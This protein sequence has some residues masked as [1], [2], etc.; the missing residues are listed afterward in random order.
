MLIQYIRDAAI[1]VCERTLAWRYEQPTFALTAGKYKYEFNKPDDTEVQALLLVTLNDSP[2]EVLELTQAAQ[3][4]PK[5]AVTSTTPTAIAEN[6]S[7]PRSITQV[8]PSEFILLPAPDAAKTYTV[9]MIYAL[10][11][12][13]T[14]VEMDEAVFNRLERPIMH[15]ALQQLLVLPQVGWSDRVL[16]EYHA[17][18][19]LASVTEARAQANLNVTRAPMSVKFPHFA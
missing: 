19:F 8:N 14:S 18:Q 1:R 11:P 17:R 2:L 9:R 13:R 7:E 3:L 12:S 4:Y 16:A 15:Y 5:W 6:G 10:R